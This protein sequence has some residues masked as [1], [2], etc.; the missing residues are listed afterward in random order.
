L[1]LI[2]ALVLAPLSIFCVY[3]GGYFFFGLVL[4]AYVASVQEWARMCVRLPAY[5]WL[6]AAFGLLYFSCCYAMFLYIRAQGEGAQL[7]F[8]LF[9][10]VWGCDI[11]AYFF[12]KMIG[13]TK[14][15]PE[16][17]PNKTWAG[18]WGGAFTSVVLA[19]GYVYF[20]LPAR[21]DALY[22]VLMAVVIAFAS[23]LGDL[24][25]SYVKR[26][27]DVKDTGS[28]IPGHGGVLDRIDSLILATVPMTFF[29]FWN[30]I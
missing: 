14:C 18:V 29:V 9:V 28:I 30:V 2:S 19:L 23:M 13:G 17:S 21:F 3:A 4:L 5:K 22:I 15:V 26:R 16:I 12:G 11:G 27:A 7:V 24:L 6:S 25:I 20:I 1:R 10:V 8:L